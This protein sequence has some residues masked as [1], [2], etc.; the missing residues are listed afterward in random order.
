VFRTRIRAIAL[1]IASLMALLVAIG[2]SW[3]H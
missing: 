1:A 2:A 3:K